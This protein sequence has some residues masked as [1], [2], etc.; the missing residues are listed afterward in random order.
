MTI[1]AWPNENLPQ[2]IAKSG[3]SALGVLIGSLQSVLHTMHTH[4]V[5]IRCSCEPKVVSISGDIKPTK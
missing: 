4:N 5:L 2:N 1:N 3:G